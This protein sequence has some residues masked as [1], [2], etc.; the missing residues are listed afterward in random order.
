MRCAICSV[1]GF[2]VTSTVVRHAITFLVL[3]LAC[4]AATL[5][6]GGGRVLAGG[7][8]RERARLLDNLYRRT[9]QAS[10]DMT[11]PRPGS[12][13][14]AS[15]MSVPLR[16]PAYPAGPGRDVNEMGIASSQA[17]SLSQSVKLELMALKHQFAAV[18]AQGPLTVDDPF[19]SRRLPA[20]ARGTSRSPRSGTF[21]TMDNSRGTEALPPKQWGLFNPKLSSN[22][23]LCD[24]R[25]FKSVQLARA[26]KSIQANERK[27]V[28]L[29]DKCK[30]ALETTHHAA[31]A[32]QD[33]TTLVN[34]RDGMI[35]ALKAR[36]EKKAAAHAAAILERDEQITMLKEKVKVKTAKSKAHIAELNT[37]IDKH[38]AR[39]VVEAQERITLVKK[40]DAAI[41]EVKQQAASAAAASQAVLMTTLAQR[42]AA[43]GQCDERDF[44][45]KELSDIIAERNGMV[46][47]LNRVVA[48][49]DAMIDK[50]GGSIASLQGAVTDR[51]AIIEQLRGEI[52]VRDA[53]IEKR[54]RAVENMTNVI[55]ERDETIEK[56]DDTI[57]H[58]EGTVTSR[59]AMIEQLEGTVADRDATI[60]RRD[61]TFEEQ[62]VQI[63]D[64]DGQ[65]LRRDAELEDLKRFIV[66]QEGTIEALTSLGEKNIAEHA[67]LVAERDATI[68]KLTS[69]ARSG[70]ENLL[71]QLAERDATIK[72][73]DDTVEAMRADA[74][75]SA[76]S[77]AKLEAEIADLEER[78]IGATGA[79]E[80]VL[81]ERNAQSLQI[82]AMEA[83]AEKAAAATATVLAAR[84]ATIEEIKAQAAKD[85][86]ANADL[87]VTR[88][89]TILELRNA[90]ER[91]DSTSTQ[92]IAKRDAEISKQDEVV[93]ELKQ[94]IAD[95][96]AEIEA[97]KKQVDEDAATHATMLV[98]RESLVQELDAL[99]V[100]AEQAVAAKAS[101]LARQRWKLVRDF[102]VIE[103]LKEKKKKDMMWNL[104]AMAARD[105]TI[106]KLQTHGRLRIRIS[107]ANALRGVRG[108]PDPY[109]TLL[110]GGRSERTDACKGTIDPRFDWEM[111]FSFESVDV[112][113]AETL[114]LEVFDQ[115]ILVL[116]NKLGGASLRLEPHRR[117]L[118]A[119]EH[120][121]LAVPIEYS[122]RLSMSKPLQLK[123]AAAGEVVISMIW[124]ARGPPI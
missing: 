23:L 25:S 122:Y 21:L 28:D 1:F 17:Q 70:E 57:A 61:R 82:K 44:R 49:R 54:D 37:A 59:D 6:G 111:V 52:M 34:E 47:E 85:A 42:D 30:Q 53:T 94:M 14:A 119:G 9:N 68:E 77:I 13:E 20:S 92:T 33:T 11:T 91:S 67:A 39:F 26:E 93:K 115:A 10:L 103:A 60:K 2:Y 48:D 24:E 41:E 89:A 109:V 84:D 56:H 114:Y 38:K 29:D 97:R 51:D 110:L 66:G 27:I 76:A 106:S 74:K 36:A 78:G 45:L 95:L 65:V 63:A 79:Y 117:A 50:R 101:L 105:N 15:P 83:E 108:M 40:H 19:L 69:A 5:A 58:L 80:A 98:D 7:A 18:D 71:G 32:L 86:T 96:E 90:I 120:I 4:R 104:A 3:L 73:R 113:L 118:E 43:I 99:K 72:E 116:D 62:R 31:R 35:E 87:V 8:V 107:H 55:A 75:N 81:A 16:M 112:A 124:E 22:T 88:D 102:G 123:K 12:R 121:E 64:R 100:L 46:N